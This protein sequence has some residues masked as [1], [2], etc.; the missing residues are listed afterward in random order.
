MEG[1]ARPGRSTYTSWL[2]PV[3]TTGKTT[4]APLAATDDGHRAVEQ[5]QHDIGPDEGMV[6]RRPDQ[7]RYINTL[8]KPHWASAEVLVPTMMLIMVPVVMVLPV[9][10]LFSRSGDAGKR[11]FEMMALFGHIRML[12]VIPLHLSLI[13]I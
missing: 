4:G 10:T 7:C 6:L 1:N 11:D 2:W 5:A 9:G 12:F 8:A 3:F 13:H